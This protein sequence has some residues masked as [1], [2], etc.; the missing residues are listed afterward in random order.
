MAGLPT[1]ATGHDR[2]MTRVLIAADDSDVSVG[3]ARTARSLFGDD[4][5]YLVVNVAE[6]PALAWGDDSMMWGY[7]YPMAIPPVA[8]AVGGPPLVVRP[9]PVP[10]DGDVPLAPSTVD[11]AEQAAQSVAQ[12]AGLGGATAIGEVGEASS[13]ILEAADRHHV[14]VIVV[15]SHERGWFS[16]LLSGSVSSSVAK[17]SSVPVLVVH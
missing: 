5:D 15:G 7:A 12:A 14:D 2:D 3:A 9:S 8:G 13:A 6:T 1:G 16:R 4:A 10:P 17:R 11:V